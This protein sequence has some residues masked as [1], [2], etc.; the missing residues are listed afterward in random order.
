MSSVNSASMRDPPVV[1]VRVKDKNRALA[2]AAA[3]RSAASRVDV[4]VRREFSAGFASGVGVAQ[5]VLA[6]AIL[7][8]A[9]SSGLAGG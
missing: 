2:A 9:V 7:F 1:V 6:S 8:A 5:A 3:A 4:V